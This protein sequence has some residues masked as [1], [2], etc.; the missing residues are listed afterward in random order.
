MRITPDRQSTARLY[1][2][3]ICTAFITNNSTSCRALLIEAVSFC[4][5][6]LTSPH[7]QAPLKEIINTLM[8]F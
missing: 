1:D 2:I 8:I 5:S 3:D 4:C 6:D 7:D